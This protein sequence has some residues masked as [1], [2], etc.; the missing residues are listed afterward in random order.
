MQLKMQANSRP[1]PQNEQRN[2]FNMILLGIAARK[3]E[4]KECAVTCVVYFSNVLT[5]HWDNNRTLPET[6]HNVSIEKSNER[7]R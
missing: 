2:V 3:G 4:P 7:G 6:N 1:W 5:E